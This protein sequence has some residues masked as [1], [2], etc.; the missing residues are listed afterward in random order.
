[1]TLL[2][3]AG[4]SLNVLRAGA[5]LAREEQTIIG[6]CKK[7]TRS[8]LCQLVLDAVGTR[9]VS[10]KNPASQMLPDTTQCLGGTAHVEGEV[11]VR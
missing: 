1:M 6:R 10:C 8:V 2:N 7:E 9:I 4:N 11:W 3:I 5:D